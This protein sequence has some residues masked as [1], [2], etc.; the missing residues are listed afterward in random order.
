MRSLDR[1]IKEFWSVGQIIDLLEQPYYNNGGQ[2]FFALLPVY[3]L[4]YFKAHMRRS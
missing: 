4:F 3:H 2:T 1:L